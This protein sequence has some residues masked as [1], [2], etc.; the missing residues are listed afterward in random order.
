MT[1]PFQASIIALRGW[2]IFSSVS[3]AAVQFTVVPPQ[4]FLYFF[5]E[6]HGH[7]S[8]R[9]TLGAPHRGS[10]PDGQLGIVE[11]IGAKT[12]WDDD[13]KCLQNMVARD[14]VEPPT[15]AFSVLRYAVV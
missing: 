14:G 7:G 1:A 13:A 15:P 12:R 5:P 6:P 4:H 2:G 3:E 9:R 8:F 10:A 11:P